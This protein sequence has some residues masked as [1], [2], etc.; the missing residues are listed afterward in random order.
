[1]QIHFHKVFLFAESCFLLLY[2][3]ECRLNLQM[4]P[5]FLMIEVSDHPCPVGDETRRGGDLD[6][7]FP[8]GLG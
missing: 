5:G 7:F 3:V 2:F 6:K 1:M 8:A 4:I